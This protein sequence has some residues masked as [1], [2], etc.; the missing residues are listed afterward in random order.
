MATLLHIDSSL[1][2]DN[3]VSRAVGVTFR[4]AWEQQHPDGTVI[5]RDL[6]TDPIPHLDVVTNGAGFAPE[7][8]RTPEQRE[9]WA[10]REK[11]I[12][13]FET[14]DA[15][16]IGA[17]MYNWAIPSTLKAWLD[18]VILGGRTMG[19]D[20]VAGKPVT[21]IASRGGSYAP[22]TPNEGHDYIEPY[23]AWVLRDQLKT[24]L[25]CI[26]PELT[27]ARSVP[28]MKDLIGLS[29]DSRDRAHEDAKN[30]AKTLAT[31]LSA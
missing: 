2:G 3:S 6:A 7:G 19:G 28:A 30:R 4:A 11:L 12:E 21:V 24:D 14:A 31:Q 27:L 20:T 17:P 25:H 5:H 1:N 9:A 8:D 26:V 13:E 15:V 29:D 18:H 23:L 16:L 22:G 10:R